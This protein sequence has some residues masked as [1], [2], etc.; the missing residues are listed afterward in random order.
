MLGR[1]EKEILFVTTSLTAVGFR[2]SIRRFGSAVVGHD[3]SKGDLDVAVVIPTVEKSGVVTH[4]RQLGGSPKRSMN[5]AIDVFDCLGQTYGYNRREPGILHLLVMS[6]QEYEGSSPLAVNI[7]A[8]TNIS[9]S[10]K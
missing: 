10:S 3:E 6:Q 9:G 4:L 8:A 7:R 1:A 5:W 2:A